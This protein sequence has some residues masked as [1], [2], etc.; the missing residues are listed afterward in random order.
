MAEK[1]HSSRSRNTS[2]SSYSTP[3]GCAIS[4]NRVP[5]CLSNV[6]R[7]VLNIF[8]PQSIVTILSSLLSSLGIPTPAPTPYGSFTD[9]GSS[10]LRLT[11]CSWEELVRAIEAFLPLGGLTT[12][13]PFDTFEGRR[14]NPGIRSFNRVRSVPLCRSEPVEGR[15]TKSSNRSRNASWLAPL[16]VSPYGGAWWDRTG[17]RLR[18]FSNDSGPTLVPLGVTS[19]SLSKPR[20]CALKNFPNFGMWYGFLS[21]SSRPMLSS[22]T[23]GRSVFCPIGD[24]ALGEGGVR[25]EEFLGWTVLGLTT[26]PLVGDNGGEEASLSL[27]PCRGERDG[28]LFPSLSYA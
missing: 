11:Y 23:A 16:G 20:V 19:R 28:D 5:G 22:D 14:S 7:N 10:S 26:P 6:R 2:P 27:L 15:R 25:G 17:I 3:P 9:R 24:C 13:L 12:P 4:Y 18:L 8:P 21:E 1:H